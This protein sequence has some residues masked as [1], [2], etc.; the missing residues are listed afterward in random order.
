MEH[1][2]PVRAAEMSV[3]STHEHARAALTPGFDAAAA[4]EGITEGLIALDANAT[5][6]YVNATAEMMLHRR[7]DELIGKNVWAAFPNDVDGAFY[8]GYAVV[9]AQR[10]PATFEEYYPSLDRWFAARFYPT[11]DE[12]MLIFVREITESKLLEEEHRHLVEFNRAITDNLAD[13]IYALDAHGCVTFLNPAAEQMLGWT[14]AELYGRDMHQA[15]HFRHADGTAFTKED[16]PI[17][18]AIQ[19]AEAVRSDA[20]MFIRKDG[21]TFPVT[22]SSA[23]LLVRNEV[24][25]SVLAFHD[26]SEQRK[27]EE[28]RVHVLHVVAHELKTPLTATKGWVQIARCSLAEPEP[29]LDEILRGA[30]RGIEQMNRLV[31]DLLQVARLERDDL[32]L[33]IARCELT[34]IC[35]QVCADQQ[36]ATGR[37]ITPRLPGKPV[38]VLADASRIRQVLTNLLT[39]ALKFSPVEHPVVLR[40]ESDGAMARVAVE[41]RGRGIAP[42]LVPLLFERFYRVPGARA[43]YGSG[44]G[45]GLGLYISRRLVELHG[46]HI[47]VESVPGQG[48]VVWFTLPLADTVP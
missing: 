40:V 44:G 4:L 12:G 18:R 39:N 38:W 9:R 43:K 23:P 17:Q 6:T 37:T 25:G 48:T 45:L 29:P 7:R 41:D 20:D 3:L 42:H 36:A 26:V 24:R 22:Y 31:D 5:V 32:T 35:E 11:P 34:R 27:L 13:G 33:V 47:D 8:Q 21:T 28:E 46:G 15:I 19:A 16:C 10:M 2:Q 1:E 14:I 30:E